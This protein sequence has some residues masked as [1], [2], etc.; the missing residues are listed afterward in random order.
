MISAGYAPGGGMKRS[1][2]PYRQQESGC[3][4]KIKG[5]ALHPPWDRDHP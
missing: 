4:G 3:A 5:F 1:D 2:K